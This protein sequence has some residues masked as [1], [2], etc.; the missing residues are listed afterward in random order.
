M[1][2]EKL[3]ILAQ[4]AEFSNEGVAVQQD[5]IWLFPPLFFLSL[6]QSLGNSFSWGVSGKVVFQWTGFLG[7]EPEKYC[8]ATREST[9]A[10]L[11]SCYFPQTPQTPPSTTMVPFH[12]MHMGYLKNKPIFWSICATL[13]RL[14]RNCRGYATIICLCQRIVMSPAQT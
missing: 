9:D 4:K 3:S 12:G 8:R 6:K 14:C 2:V 10:S 7:T 11:C 13:E 1:H 5:M